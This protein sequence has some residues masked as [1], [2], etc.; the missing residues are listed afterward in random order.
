MCC[1]RDIMKKRALY[2]LTPGHNNA[3]DNLQAYCIR[4]MLSEF[5]ETVLEFDFRHTAKGLQ[6]VQENDTIFLSSGGN[7]GDL[8]LKGE[9]KRREIIESCHGNTI[10]S[11]PQT[12]Q[13]NSKDEAEKSSAIYSEHPNLYIFARDTKSYCIAKELFPANTVQQLPDPVFTLSHK[14]GKKRM[15][16][17][18][19]FRNDKEGEKHRDKHIKINGLCRHLDPYVNTIDILLKEVTQERMFELIDRISTYRLVVTDRL[20]GTI[21]AAI[22]GTPC[23]AFQTINHKITESMY[24]HKRFGTK[25]RLVDSISEFEEQIGNIPEPFDYDPSDAVGLYNQVISA[26]EAT[27]TIPNLNRV[28]NTI[29]SRR[30]VR[31]WKEAVL[32]NNVLT[33]IVKAGIYAP[34]GSNAQCV[35][36]RIIV[37]RSEIEAINR[38]CFSRNCDIPSAVIMAGYDFD[39][40]HTINYRHKN[41]TWEPL[42]YQDVA[43]AIQNMQLY[44]ESIGLSCCWLSFFT[45]RR[46]DFLSSWN[47]KNDNVEY[48]S[49]LAIGFAKNELAY[50]AMHQRR[51]VERNNVEDYIL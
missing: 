40:K 29:I 18:C 46:Q 42:K 49:G 10:V 26:I 9:M 38:D 45:E 25:T 1:D 37:T 22:T 19:I 6:Q 20:H 51:K 16:I 5:Y 7:L 30:T 27:D 8:Y 2:F 36:F 48:I 32:P 43:A 39:V 24:W 44:C 50:E 34:S 17:L 33:D 31:R 13:F 15:G 35:K 4:K 47:I 12:I 14:S 41:P 28:E 11:F 3:G 21:F 23:I